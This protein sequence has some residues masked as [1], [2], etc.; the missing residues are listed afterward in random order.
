[1]LAYLAVTYLFFVVIDLLLYSVQ[2]LL[3]GVD[4][5]NDISLILEIHHFLGSGLEGSLKRA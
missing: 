4:T 5:R 3:D 1:V 2:F